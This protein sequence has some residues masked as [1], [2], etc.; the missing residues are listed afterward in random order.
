[1]AECIDV[2]F[3]E[4]PLKH[5][6]PALL[7]SADIQAYQK[8]CRLIQ[9]E[10][11]DPSSDRLKAASYKILCKGDV[12]WGEHD[13]PSE[14]CRIE[15]G[16]DFDVPQN[17]LVFIA[18]DVEFCLPRYIAARFNLTI[19]LVHQGLLLGTG[20]LVDP[21]FEGRLLI[22]LHNLTKRAVKLKANSGLIWMEFTKLSPNL[23]QCI[24]GE[25]F[26]FAESFQASQKRLPVDQ[27]FRK[28]NGVPAQ[29]ILADNA[30]RWEEALRSVNDVQNRAERQETW[31]RQIGVVA[32][33]ATAIAI[34]ALGVSVWQTYASFIAIVQSSQQAVDDSRKLLR[35]GIQGNSDVLK[36]MA[37]RVQKLE[38]KTDKRLGPDEEGLKQGGKISPGR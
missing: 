11:F 30:F 36:D 12:F 25:R 2:G 37:T 13:K 7:N 10:V 4:D 9:G 38:I 22:P 28:T 29:S 6:P 19:G 18:P 16:R 31:L 17:G 14:R 20:P 26:L 15:D 23:F 27:Y 32:I 8:A 1:M 3:P 5:I 34:V 24:D 35:D 33:L 21:G